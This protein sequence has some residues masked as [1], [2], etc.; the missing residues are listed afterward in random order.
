MVV[1]PARKREK[2]KKKK[3]ARISEWSHNELIVVMSCDELAKNPFVPLIG[4]QRI[5][6]ERGLKGAKVGQRKWWT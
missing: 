1:G 4:G 3:S 6:T 5:W 2:K